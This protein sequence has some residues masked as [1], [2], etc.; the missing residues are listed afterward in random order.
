M[1]KPCPECGKETSSAAAYCPHCGHPILPVPPA[2]Q[3]VPTPA[4]P[5]SD[6]MAGCLGFLLGPV[7]LWYKGRWVEG[8][9]WLIM[10]LLV[11][12]ATGFLAAPFF[13]IGMGLHAVLAK[14]K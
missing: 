4:E 13:W 9:A 10:A 3:I 8:F 5:K 2:V 6:A 1:L 7:G 12:P 14:P 11:V